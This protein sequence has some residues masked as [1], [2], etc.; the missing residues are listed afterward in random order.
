MGE[1]FAA[2]SYGYVLYI[3]VFCCVMYADISAATLFAESNVCGIQWG[4]FVYIIAHLEIQVVMEF[5]IIL[6]IDVYQI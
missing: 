2:L 4:M 3:P 5:D 1:N 6:Q